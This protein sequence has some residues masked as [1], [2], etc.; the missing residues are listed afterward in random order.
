MAFMDLYKSFFFFFLS[1]WSWD[2]KGRKNC[3]L[4]VEKLWGTDCVHREGSPQNI[5]QSWEL[6]TMRKV[7]A[8]RSLRSPVCLPKESGF[9]SWNLDFSSLLRDWRQALNN[10]SPHFITQQ[11]RLS[12]SLICIEQ[13]QAGYKAAKP[14]EWKCSTFSDSRNP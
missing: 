10:A 1:D 12:V 6:E 9:W 3:A 4:L 13:M 8:E 14:K 7:L 5:N 2:R 11:A